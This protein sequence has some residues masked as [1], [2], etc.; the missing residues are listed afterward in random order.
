VVVRMEFVD[1][2]DLLDFIER[3]IKRVNM[4]QVDRDVLILFLPP[5]L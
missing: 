4:R 3:E 1:V 2:I 5:Q